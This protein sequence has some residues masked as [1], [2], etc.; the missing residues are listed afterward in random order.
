MNVVKDELM[1]IGRAADGRD[2]SS[3]SP[4]RGGQSSSVASVASLPRNDGEK[5]AVRNDIRYAWL[6]NPDIQKLLDDISEIIA[7][8]YIEVAKKNKDVF[9]DSC[10]RRNDSGVENES[11]DIRQ[12]FIGESE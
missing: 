7:N 8:E 10:F 9:V 6:D 4:A 5:E 12:V 3:D 11:S 2:T 1:G